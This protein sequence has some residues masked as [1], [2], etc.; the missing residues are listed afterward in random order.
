MTAFGGQ[1]EAI[2]FSD[3]SPKWLAARFR[4]RISLRQAAGRACSPRWTR[5][6]TR[7]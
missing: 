6:I 3:S 7:Y 2:A 1:S 5:D 4:V